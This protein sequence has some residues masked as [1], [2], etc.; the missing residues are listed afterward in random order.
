MVDPFVFVVFTMMMRLSIV[1]S[2]VVLLLSANNVV[3]SASALEY[4]NEPLSGMAQDPLWFLEGSHYGNPNQG[5]Q[6]DEKMFRVQGIDGDLCTPP[7][8]DQGKCPT[9]V[10][11]GV[12]AHPLCGLNSPDGTQ[13][14]VLLC[15]PSSNVNV[16]VDADMCG[17]A[18]CRTI[19]GQPG[20]GICTY[21]IEDDDDDEEEEDMEA[22]AW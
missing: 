1:A 14:C 13:Y 22:G 21:D 7:C 10:P 17:D 4:L 2:L 6:P 5:C 8:D 18:K 15:Q 9:D 3:T 20:V 16:A 19:K 12:T 11:T